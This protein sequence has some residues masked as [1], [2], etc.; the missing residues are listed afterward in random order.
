M[1]PGPSRRRRFNAATGPGL[2]AT[3]MATTLLAGPALAQS[4]SPTAAAP[5]TAAEAAQL[6]A[7][8]LAIQA[9]AKALADQ[10]N[11]IEH[12][13]DAAVG[14]ATPVQTAAAQKPAE[15]G[16]AASPPGSQIATLSPPPGSADQTGEANI[17][18]PKTWGDWAPQKGFVLARTDKGEVDMTLI[19]YF[20]YL[21]QSALDPTYTDYFGHT[22]KL[23]LKEDVQLN[24]ANLTFKG[25]FLDERF[26]Y[27]LF[28]WTNNAAQGD[29]GGLAVGG[30]LNY[31]FS[32][33]ISLSAGVDAL[34]TTRSTTGN[35]PNW[36][37]N[38]NRLMADE[39][40]RGSFTEGIWMD[41]RFGRF[42]YRVTA[43]DNLS[44]LGV[45]ASQLAPGLKTYAGY[46]RWMPTTGE[47]GPGAGFGDYEDHKKI[48][49]LLEAHFTY[50][51]E[52]AQEQPSTNAIENSQI[53]L[54]DGERLFDPNVFGTQYR[55]TNA[56]YKMAAF[57]A[58]AKYHGFALESEYYIR[59]V[60][61]FVTTGPLPY[62]NMYDTGVSLQAS[63]MI[64]QKKLQAY[65]TYS[66]IWG[67]FG[68]PNEAVFGL[69]WYPLHNKGFRITPNAMWFDNSPVGYSG[70]PYVVG[71]HGWAFYMDAAVALN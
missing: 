13:L 62:T 27:L 58:A 26:R 51:R 47:F 12:R 61:D 65:A 16:A 71:G 5:M 32:D 66:H 54:S 28:I 8:L 63:G 37:R 35:Y 43:G 52:D 67:Q 68:S 60:D 17:F 41:G 50:S 70:V 1:M 30:F 46:L 57:D 69:N 25:W 55:I 44:I 39:F 56:T 6:R 38:D 4:A 53:R 49:T 40:M 22:T 7:Q 33:L 29:S 3:L 18:K 15:A 2:I 20:R 10:A 42:Q 11:T 24:K 14:P 48:A 21:N 31:K 36:L 59:W 34:P 45:S 23:D 19:T 9:Q 64:L